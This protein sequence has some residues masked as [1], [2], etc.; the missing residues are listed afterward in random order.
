MHVCTQMFLDTYDTIPF[1]VMRFL[2]GEINYGGRVTEEQ[3]RV[4][5]TTRLVGFPRLCPDGN[6]DRREY[7][8]GC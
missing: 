4:E 6:V 2:C 5:H 7:C 8:M 3:V 1:A